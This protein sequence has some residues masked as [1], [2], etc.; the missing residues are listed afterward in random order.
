MRQLKTIALYLIIG[1]F[2]LTL[3]QCG[4]D[5][6]EPQG[7]FIKITS[8]EPESPASLMFEENIQII[9]EYNIV[10]E[11]GA[12][13]WIIPQTDGDDSPGYRYSSSGVYNGSGD[14]GVIVSIADQED[15]VVVDQLWVIMRDPD[16]DEDIFSEYIDVEYSFGN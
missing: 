6:D 2:S 4:N 3:Y 16:T 8:I 15:P 9:Y 13:M 1:L 14:R 12:Y 10:N 7:N 11:N 5:D